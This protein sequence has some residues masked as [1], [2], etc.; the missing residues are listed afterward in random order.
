MAGGQAIDLRRRG[1]KP[2]HRPALEIM[3]RRKTGALIQASV[4]LGAIAAG[5]TAGEELAALARFGAEIGLA[6]QIQDD[7]LDV[8]RRDASSGQAHR[9]RCARMQADLSEPAGLSRRA[10]LA[11]EHRDRAVAALAV[12]GARGTCAAGSRALSP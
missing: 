1:P 2:T 6:F 9:R 8:D 5:V 12:L 4:D 7:I 11:R 3:H 10:R